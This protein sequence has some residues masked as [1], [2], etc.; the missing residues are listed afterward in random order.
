MLHAAFCSTTNCS[1]VT[2]Q[3]VA[4]SRT[5]P[6][7]GM[8][9]DKA[10]LGG[11]RCSRCLE[12]DISPLRGPTLHFSAATRARP[13]DRQSPARQL[14][15]FSRF[16]AENSPSQDLSSA[17]PDGRVNNIARNRV[18][19]LNANRTSPKKI[20]F[21][22]FFFY[23]AKGRGRSGT[24]L[25]QHLAPPSKKMKKRQNHQNFKFLPS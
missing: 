12:P 18:Y 20:F 3:N 16:R 19:R 2:A 1:R 15:F 7:L 8:R 10:Q 11:R 4:A 24:L 22:L 25:T 13:G 17:P 21:Y 14:R 23:S 9:T 5:S 6:L